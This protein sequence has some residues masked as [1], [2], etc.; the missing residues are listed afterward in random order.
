MTKVKAAPPGDDTNT[1]THPPH[2]IGS[3]QHNTAARETD[4]HASQNSQHAAEVLSRPRED[5]RQ[6]LIP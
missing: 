2:R 5:E 1:V 3:H 6:Q 4:D